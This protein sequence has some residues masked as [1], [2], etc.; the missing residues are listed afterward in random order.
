MGLLEKAQ[1]NEEEFLS[2]KR[3]KQRTAKRYQD[4]Q[5]PI[6]T[7]RIISYEK[8]IEQQRSLLEKAR[9]QQMQSGETSQS[10]PT[11]GL[12]Q[13]T[14]QA[15]TGVILEFQNKKIEIIEEQTGFGWK[16]QGTKRIIYDHTNH[17]F[18]NSCVNCCGL[19]LVRGC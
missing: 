8:T 19:F 12:E 13:Q 10:S 2:N 4:D 5:S 15:S 11:L 9:Q 18:R 16:K 14:T 7:Y 6:E 17:G 1:E 3:K